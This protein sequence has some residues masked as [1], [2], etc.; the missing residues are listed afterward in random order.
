MIL[1]GLPLSR[2]ALGYV[3]LACVGFALCVRS[4]G[5]EDSEFRSRTLMHLNRYR[6]FLH[7]E[8]G[9]VRA[10]WTVERVIGVQAL[11]FL[12]LLVYS[13]RDLW[14]L[15]VLPV[16]ALC[17]MILLRIARKKRVEGIEKQMEGWLGALS[18][19]LEAA[20]SLGDALEATILS[21]GSPL[22]EELELVVQEMRLGLP[23]D[24]ALEAW[25]YRVRNAT[26]SLALATLRIGRQTGGSLPHVLKEAAATIREMERLHG[27]VRT[28]TAEGR[29]QSWVIGGLPVLVYLGLDNW[30]PNHFD[31][32][33]NTPVGNA[34]V[35]LAV[36]LWLAAL[37]A[38]KKILAVRI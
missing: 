10:D 19:A 37:F 3:L 2:A 36:V 31:P 26:H 20:P 24:R 38:I 34:L 16:V 8:L 14:S 12:C 33:K 17:P 9:F 15:L 13:L 5:D 28:K 27:V 18:R 25:E 1:L 23:L 21:S 6:S 4:L 29:A 35:A 30:K 22:R 7:I 32:L 11:L